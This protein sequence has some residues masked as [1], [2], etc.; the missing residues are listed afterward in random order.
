MTR[1][2]TD[3]KLRAMCL[4]SMAHE[5]QR[6][7]TDPIATELPFED[8]FQMMVDLEYQGRLK[9][10]LDRLLRQSGI[11]HRDAS[12]ADMYYGEERNLHR[13]TVERY[14]SCI[15]IS[16]GRNLLVMGPTGCGKTFLSSALGIEACKRE[17]SVRYTSL[18]ELLID[19][20]MAG[21]DHALVKRVLKHYRHPDLLI[22]DEFLRW[23]LTSTEANQLFRIVNHRSDTKKP[24]LICS[25]YP[26]SEWTQQIEDPVNADALV[27]R[28]IHTPYKLFI[29]ENGRGKSMREVFSMR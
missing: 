3:R 17:H 20:E 22:I 7:S 24:I 29:N 15:F 2:E 9:R 1:S 13:A 14:A 4:S 18:E 23:K 27:D 19:I 6:Q 5:Y 11:V 25:Q 10:K 8:R 16:E 26:C 12:I 21:N 28:L